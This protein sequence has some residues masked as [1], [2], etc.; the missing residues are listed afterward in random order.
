MSSVSALNIARDLY[1]GLTR[2]EADGKVLPAAAS[3][4]QVADGGRRYTFDLRT[5]LHWS[6]GESLATADSVRSLQRAVD[7]KTCSPFA[8]LLSPI[9]NADEIGRASCRERVCQ[10]V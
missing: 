4:W 10:Y 8:Q 3:G 2:I 1:E 6:N 5:D 9:A 7:P